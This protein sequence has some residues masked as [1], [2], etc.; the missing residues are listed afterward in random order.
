MKPTD[1]DRNRRERLIKILG[2]VRLRTE[3]EAELARALEASERVGAQRERA[4]CASWLE[5]L[6]CGD[7]GLHLLLQEVARALRQRGPVEDP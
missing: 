2:R 6:A 7:D 3:R 1:A 5:S 4:R